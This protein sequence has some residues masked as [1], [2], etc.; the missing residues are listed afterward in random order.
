MK[1]V[2]LIFLLLI[3]R[4]CFAQTGKQSY[5]NTDNIKSPEILAQ[6]LTASDTTEEQKVTSIFKW[7]TENIDYNVKRF[8]N[9]SS[10]RYTPVIDEEDDDTTAPLKPLYER[11]AIQV[12]RRRTAV[13]GGYA[14]LFK[15]LCTHAGIRCEV[16]TG[17]GKTS[18]GR[19]D[20]RFTSNHRWNAVFFDTA[21]HLLDVTWASGFI[22]Y[23]DQFDRLYNP[24]YFLTAP[25]DFIKDHYPED[26][27]WTLLPKPPLINEFI[28]SPF[29]TTAF[30]R[31]YIRSYSPVSG[32]IDANIGDS[33]VFELEADRAER[34]WIADLPYADSNSV[35]I[36]QC[37]GAV[38]PINII[39]GN[40]ISAVYKVTSADIEWLHIVY[41]DE[42]IMR[43]K[44]NV[45]KENIPVIDSLGART[46]Q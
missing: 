20:K 17:L 39:Q 46:N 21:W 14:N 24:Y 11:V 19:L 45:R 31:F 28:Y 35:F 16:I 34:L 13:C 4:C 7:I 23:K 3:T 8:E 44:L 5:F 30:N 10:Y 43:Y 18:T 6:L 27:R 15:S 2:M 32:I 29:K 12:L 1:N 22:N 9:N 42:I 38:K 37:C 26:P 36:M 40:K 25:E 33:I 41:D